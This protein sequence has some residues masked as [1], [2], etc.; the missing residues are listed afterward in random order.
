VRGREI[1]RCS[2]LSFGRCHGRRKDGGV[3]EWRRD[4]VDRCRGGEMAGVVELRDRRQASLR[5]AFLT[6]DHWFRTLAPV[7]RAMTLSTSQTDRSVLGWN[8]GAVKHR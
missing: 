5:R 1:S 4:E 8:P 7:M 2:R 3:K 6:C